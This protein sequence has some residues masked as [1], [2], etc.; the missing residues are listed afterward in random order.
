MAVRV[1]PKIKLILVHFVEF[2]I[3]LV[4]IPILLYPGLVDRVRL[5]AFTFVR[6][7]PDR[8]SLERLLLAAGSAKLGRMQHRLGDAVREVLV[9]EMSPPE[10]RVSVSCSMFLPFTVPEGLRVDRLC[11]RHSNR[12]RIPCIRAI[13][14]G[15]R[16]HFDFL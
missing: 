13:V 14:I 15:Q 11:R 8:F 5:I 3:A 9:R 6:L 2:S 1:S 4:F 16:T 10:F 12:E 7:R